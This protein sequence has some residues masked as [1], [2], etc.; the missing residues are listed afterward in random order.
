MNMEEK[1]ELINRKSVCFFAASK[2]RTSLPKRKSDEG[3]LSDPNQFK[4]EMAKINAGKIG[5]LFGYKDGAAR[6]MAF[7]ICGLLIIVASVLSLCMDESIWDI[8]L[9]IVALALGYLFGKK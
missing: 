1:T 3:D 8:V 5:K 7:I 9:P 6:N 2:T 4:M